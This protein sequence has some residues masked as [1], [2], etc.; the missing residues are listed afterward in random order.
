LKGTP[1]GG[2]AR[3]SAHDLS[4]YN[5]TGLAVHDLAITILA[6]AEAEGLDRPQIPA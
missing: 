5:S 4:I 2:H 1:E 3:R 6:F